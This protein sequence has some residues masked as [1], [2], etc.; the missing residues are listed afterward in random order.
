[1]AKGA[2][3]KNFVI[4]KIQEAFGADFIGEVDKKIYVWSK[5][6][7]Q[8]VQVAISLTCPKNPVG[9]INTT[10]LDVGNSKAGFDFENDE[11]FVAVPNQTNE[12][13]EEEK[14]NLATLLEKLGL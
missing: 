10:K 1:M 14:Q 7:G 13:S 6:D 3:A 11:M 2:E 8:K 12:I 5:E 9:T 4:Q